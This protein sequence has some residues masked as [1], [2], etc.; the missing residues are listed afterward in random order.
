MDAPRLRLNSPRVLMEVFGPEVVLLDFQS[1]SYF[2]VLQSG[3]EMLPRLA[4]GQTAAEVLS[5][6]SAQYPAAREEL[7]LNI[8][9]FVHRLLAEELLVPRAEGEPADPVAATSLVI[10]E[11]PYLPPLLEKFEDL[12]ELLLLDPIHEVAADGWPAPRE[13]A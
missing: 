4:A 2:S 6:L 8:P 13:A 7:A 5:E 9:D 12:Q 10:A 1:G 11:N 3:A